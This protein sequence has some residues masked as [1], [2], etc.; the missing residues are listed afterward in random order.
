MHPNIEGSRN[1]PMYKKYFVAAMI[2][3]LCSFLPAQTH[4]T[5][6]PKGT[7]VEKRHSDGTDE[8]QPTF[9]K[10][11][12]T[13]E[14]VRSAQQKLNDDGYNAGTPD[15]KIGPATQRAIRKYQS[16]KNITVTGKLDES[17]LTHLNVGATNTMA[18]APSAFGN[19]AKAAGHDLK[20]R[21]PIAAAKAFGKGVGHASK[22][23]AEGTKAG[24]VGTTGKIANKSKP[25]P[26]GK[27]PPR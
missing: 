18:T 21:H 22:A 8:V 1:A 19:G 5:K 15:G 16:D 27:Q 24:V 20:E 23:V 10:V 6:A 3:A 11:R 7:T 25:S 13:P 2:I 12:V 14:V 26:E 17:T 4:K 9:K